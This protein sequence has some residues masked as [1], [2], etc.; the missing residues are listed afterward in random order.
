M[1]EVSYYVTHHFSS[2]LVCSTW[3]GRRACNWCVCVAQGGQMSI[4]LPQG[5]AAHVDVIVQG[6]RRG[7]SLRRCP[8]GHE[9][10][11]APGTNFFKKEFEKTIAC[12]FFLKFG[13]FLSFHLYNYQISCCGANY[14]SPLSTSAIFN[15][16]SIMGT[17][18][19]GRFGS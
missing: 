7:L 17:F 13:I 2:L 9:P 3:G 18:K 15:I 16:K 12:D 6:T 11:N 1:C 19:D 14:S 8:G 4:Q 10:E 5:G